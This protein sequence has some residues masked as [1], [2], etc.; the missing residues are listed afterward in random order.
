MDRQLVDDL[1]TFDAEAEVEYIR[2]L[3]EQ[4]SCPVVFG[5][6]DLQEGNILLQDS[7]NNKSSSPRKVALIDFEY[8]AYNYRSFDIANHFAERV[9]GYRLPSSPYFTVHKEEYPNKEQQVRD[10]DTFTVSF[11]YFDFKH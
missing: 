2:G 7:S 4:L 8:C 6:N 3:V 1:R 9:Y 11:T 5:H 10:V